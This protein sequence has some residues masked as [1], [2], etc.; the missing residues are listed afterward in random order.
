MGLEHTTLDRNYTRYL[1]I[2]S[3][4]NGKL[5]SVSSRKPP[6]ILHCNQESRVFGLKTY[7]LS[8][9]LSPEFARVYFS[10]KFD[11][12]CISWESLGS[13]PGR[14]S[15]KISDGEA[16]KIKSILVHEEDLLEHAEENLR[17]WV[18]FK[19]LMSIGVIC[20]VNIPESGIGYSEEAMAAYSEKI[21]GPGDERWP[22]LVCLRNDDDLCAGPCKRHWWFDGW[23][24]RG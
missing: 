17:E 14:L 8:F 19:N 1:C 5:S 21:D 24:Q 9:A 12:V 3:I 23:N 15:R 2:Q 6:A 4:T 22:S 7:E 13:S 10:F 18:R 20:D 11:T 16:A